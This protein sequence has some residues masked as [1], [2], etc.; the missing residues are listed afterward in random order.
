MNGNTES[1]FKITW[2][3]AGG[4]G[5][6]VVTVGFDGGTLHTDTVRVTSCDKREVF[7][8][9]VAE[10]FPG[11]EEDDVREKLEGVAAVVG[12]TTSGRSDDQDSSDDVSASQSQAT[13]IVNL[14]EGLELFHTPGAGI[15]D[16]YVVVPQ[17]Q[18]EVVWKIKSHEFEQYMARKFFSLHKKVPRAQAV[19]DGIAMLAATARWERKQHDVHVRVAGHDGAVYW[20]LA[21]EKGQVIKI[22]RDGWEV[23]PS[24][25]LPVR[26]LRKRGM[27]AL[28]VPVGGGT[29]REFAALANLQEEQD[30]LLVF[31]FLIGCLNPRGPYLILRVEGEHGSGKSTVCKMVRDLIDPAKP[32]LR[33]VPRSDRD[34][35]IAATNS[36]I[37]GFD[38]ISGLHKATSDALCSLATGGGYAT[39]ALYANDEE[40]L[41]DA[42]RPILVN[43]IDNVGDRPDFLDRSATVVLPRIPDGQRRLE[44]DLWA[45]FEEAKPRIVGALCSAVAQALLNFGSVEISGLPRM[46]DA[47]YWIVAAEPA[48][49]CGPGRFLEL[50]TTNRR[51]ADELAI[52]SSPIGLAVLALVERDGEWSGTA[53]DLV[54]ALEPLAGERAT[55][56]KDWPGTSNRMG[57]ALLRIAPNLRALGLVVELDERDSTRTRKRMKYLKRGTWKPSEPSEP[58]EGEPLGGMDTGSV[59][60]S[61]DEVSGFFW[62]G[63][64]PGASIPGPPMTLPDVSDVSDDV[65]ATAPLGANEDGE[66]SEWS[67]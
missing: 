43:G 49:G 22:T 66:V 29:L 11:I 26:F 37:S 2:A 60:Q 34:L 44:I 50:F 3:P 12:G 35:M 10:L 55:K 28:P 8:K 7:L 17:D 53:A 39:R 46:A 21:N 64:K 59:G 57:H 61:A 33:A 20:D 41:F 9:K 19:N 54:E 48:L 65:P 56:A 38:N 6:V 52:E 63:R 51:A 30:R 25:G 40:M 18:H 1:E 45:Q 16:S 27:L 32:P 31:G 4:K 15:A 14:A 24:K 5:V 67:A 47:V 13:L 62:E 42:M 58:S 36:W 23:V